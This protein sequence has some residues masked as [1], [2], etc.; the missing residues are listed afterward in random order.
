MPM[1]A[2]IAHMLGGNQLLSNWILMHALQ[3]E[4]PSTVNLAKKSYLRSS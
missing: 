2:I 1:G 4:K 3:E